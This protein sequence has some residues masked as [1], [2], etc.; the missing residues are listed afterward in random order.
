MNQPLEN[1]DSM[2]VFAINQEKVHYQ[3]SPGNIYSVGIMTPQIS[4]NYY[5]IRYVKTIMQSILLLTGVSLSS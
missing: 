5:K 4:L 2:S 3:S 1:F